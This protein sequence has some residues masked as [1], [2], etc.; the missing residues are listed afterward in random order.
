MKRYRL[1]DAWG[2]PY[3][4]WYNDTDLKEL[5]YSIFSLWDWD[6]MRDD[7]EYYWKT[8]EDAVNKIYS[9]LLKWERE[10]AYFV[11]EQDTPFPED[12]NP[13]NYF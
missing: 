1:T 12:E 2:E 13:W 6:W 10:L 11:E 7:E 5:A 4:T 9:L 3:A 8:D